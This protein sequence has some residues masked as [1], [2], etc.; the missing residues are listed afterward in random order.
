VEVMFSN[1]VTKKIWSRIDID[2]TLRDYPVKRSRVLK[3]L[4][5]FDEKGWIRLQPR[6]SVEVYEILNKNIEIEDLTRR[7]TD[8]FNKKEV[9]EIQRIHTM[10]RFFESNNCLSRNLSLYFGEK[11]I[12]QCGHCSVCTLGKATIPP[13]TVLPPLA[14]KNFA[15]LTGDFIEAMNNNVSIPLLTRFLCGITMPAFSRQKIK[16]LPGFGILEDY[17]YKEVEEYVKKNFIKS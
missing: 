10:V 7:L 4:E 8:L 5:Y 15:Q 1:T 9:R 13:A 17:P 6:Q 16:H 2:G 14:G 11:G 3:A 12:E